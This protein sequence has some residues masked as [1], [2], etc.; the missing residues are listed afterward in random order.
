MEAFVPKS[1][2]IAELGG[3]EDYAYNYIE[4]VAGENDLMKDTA[5]RDKLIQQRSL[6]VDD[7]E[8]RTLDWIS[9]EGDAE[10]IKKT[11]HEIAQKL[12]DDYWNLDP[13]IRARSYYDRIG[14]INSGNLQFY[15]QAVATSMPAKPAVETSADDID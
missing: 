12:R 4:P 13:Y 1:R 6:I 11:R 8:K 2:I 5:T 10:A 3:P 14:L 15:P 7:Y 9:A